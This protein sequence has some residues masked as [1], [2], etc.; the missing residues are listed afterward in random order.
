HMFLLN[1]SKIASDIQSSLYYVGEVSVSR[2]YPDRLVITAND[3]R[4]VGYIALSGG[5]WLIDKNCKLLEK[6]DA[7]EIGDAIH[8][9]GITPVLPS[10]G[11]TVNVEESESAKVV[12]LSE[13][14]TYAE[15]QEITE[16]I[17]SI[18]MDNVSNPR[19]E[20][21]DR[22]TVKLGAGTDVEYKM[23]MLSGVIEKLSDSDTGVID[24]SDTSRIRFQPQ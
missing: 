8:I 9:S 4:A 24:L 22:F 13:I 19:F 10:E 15:K 16:G 2:R 7:D 17:T 12:Y 21:L 3:N 6:V 1:Q 14:L 18:D 23:Q 5:Y 20:Y 11:K